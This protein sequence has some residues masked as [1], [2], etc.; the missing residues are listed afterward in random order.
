MEDT[1]QYKRR[2]LGSEMRDQIIFSSESLGVENSVGRDRDDLNY[3]HDL[4]QAITT[5]QQRNDSLILE[6]LISV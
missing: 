1:P 4:C 2:M 3:E 6:H 5:S